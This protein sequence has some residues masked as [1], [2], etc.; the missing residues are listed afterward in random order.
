[1]RSHEARYPLLAKKRGRAVVGVWDHDPMVSNSPSVMRSAAGPQRFSGPVVEE[2]LVELDTGG[3]PLRLDLRELNTIERGAGAVLS[4]ALLGTLGDRPLKVVL[5]GN[6]G[7]WIATSG[8]AFALANRE[9]DTAI[10]VAS[11]QQPWSDWRRDWRPGHIEPLRAMM[12][13]GSGELFAPAE[14][15]ETTALP[16]LYGPT[17]AAFVNPHLTRPNL[18]HH[19]LTT[20]LWPWLDRL[21]PSRQARASD[22]EERTRW[23]ADVGEV[24][25][26]VLGNVCAHARRNDGRRVFSLVQVSVT[27]GGGERSSNRLHLCVQ[28]TGPGIPATARPKISASAAAGMTE[29]QLVGRLL[30]GSLTPWGRGRGQ[31]LPR[32]VEICRRLHGTLRVATK[33]TRAVVDTQT[34]N[35]A[36]RTSQAAFRLDGTVVTLTLPVLGV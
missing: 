22:P 2:L 28:D 20:L 32:V 18:E 23:V 1:M 12:P 21:L 16:D 25:D 35:C 6:R 8:L 34:A 26:E 10:D 4:N 7:D 15:G 31:G 17:F 11:E 30:E 29:Q 9:G 33:T 5:E 13:Q 27:R 3:N 24:V 14:L 19:P 36:V